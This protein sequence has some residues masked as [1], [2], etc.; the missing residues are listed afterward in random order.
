MGLA[1][2]WLHTQQRATQFSHDW[3]KRTENSKVGRFNFARISHNTARAVHWIESENL[4]FQR[5]PGS[6]VAEGYDLLGNLGQMSDAHSSVVSY[7]SQNTC[8]QQIA[9][10]KERCATATIAKW[11]QDALPVTERLN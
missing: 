9:E 6:R 7:S 4:I 2:R 10:R 1:C 11:G 8:S 5:C 3:M